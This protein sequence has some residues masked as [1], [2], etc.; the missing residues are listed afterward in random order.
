MTND[1]QTEAHTNSHKTRKCVPVRVRYVAPFELLSYTELLRPSCCHMACY[2][3]Q[4]TWTPQH[5]HR[6]AT[7]S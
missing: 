1:T 7:P 5:T 3:T 6:T 4:W 2:A